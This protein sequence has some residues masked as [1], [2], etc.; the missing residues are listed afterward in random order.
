MDG[1]L[2]PPRNPVEQR[3]ARNSQ[4]Q[5]HL[6]ARCRG[7][8][9]PDEVTLRKAVSERLGYDPFFTW[10][11]RS[12]VVEIDRTASGP[13]AG[14]VQLFADDGTLVG[15]RKLGPKTDCMELVRTLAL[16]TAIALDDLDPTPSPAP[17]STPAAGESA[18]SPVPP[19]SP[20][21]DASSHPPAPPVPARPPPLPTSVAP[22]AV[23]V[24]ITGAL[25]TEPTT[26][27]G[28]RLALGARTRRFSLALEA[29]GTLPSSTATR[30]GGRIQGALETGSLVPC[31]HW[32]MASGCAVISAGTLVLESIGVSWP[33][34]G[35]PRAAQ[36]GA[37]AGVELGLGSHFFAV[38]DVAAMVL[39]TP[40]TVRL[41]GQEVY[42]TSP[43]SGTGAIGMGMRF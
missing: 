20:Q 32:G 9:C 3:G 33:A 8:G 17:S 39:T 21:P 10:A 38:A 30:F 18:P 6:R 25:G 13:F 12:V 4:L 7:G 41:N 11:K 42:A 15:E 16:A 14:R 37:R 43:V 23:A 19:P 27:V 26:A 40:V 28:G 29:Q 2:G 1:L 31:V 35:A 24:A 22:W 34:R 36:S 5:A